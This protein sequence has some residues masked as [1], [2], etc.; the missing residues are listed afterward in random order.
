MP[1]Q[2]VTLPGRII[3]VPGRSTE[4]RMRQLARDHPG[5]P[6]DPG[7]LAADL[8]AR[9]D[10]VPVTFSEPR[11][12]G[13]DWSLLVHGRTYLVRLFLTKRFQDAYTIAAVHPLRMKD[14]HRLAQGCLLVRAHGG[15]AA[16]LTQQQ[17]PRGST[18]H[19]PQLAAEWRRFKSSLADRAVEPRLSQSQA[20][21]L[22]TLDRMIDA[23]ERIATEEETS[24]RPYPYQAIE[25]AGER[26]EGSRSVYEFRLASGRRPDEGAFV[27][28]R[29]EPEQRGQVTRVTDGSVLV[30]FDTPVDW[31]HLRPQGELQVT[32][33]RIVYDTQRE[34]VS[35]LR[36]GQARNSGLLPAVVDHHLRGFRA[37]AAMPRE[38]LDPDQTEAFRRAVATEDLLLV[39]GPPGTGKTRTIRQIA[40]AAAVG[41][42]RVLITSHSNRAVD[43]VLPELPRDLVTVR[44]GHRLRVTAEGQPYLLENQ[45]EALRTD[46]TNVTGLSLVAY[47]QLADAELWTSELRRATAATDLALNTETTALTALANA[48]RRVGGAAQARV[49]GIAAVRDARQRTLDR[50]SKRVDR[51][52]RRRERALSRTGWPMLGSLLRA[53]ARRAERRV[54]TEREQGARLHED[55]RR[56]AAELAVA[57]GE[58]DAATWHDPAVAAAR[59][60]VGEAVRCRDSC[61]ADALTAAS[62]SSAAVA[63]AEV[64]PPVRAGDELGATMSDLAGLTEWLDRR[65]PLHAAR[66]RLLAAWHA[67][68]SE[69]TDQLYP[70]LIGYADVIASTSTGAASRPELSAVD[71]DLAIIDEAGQIGMA[72]A[73]VPLARANRGVLVGDPKQLPPFLNSDVE[74]WGKA[75]GDPVVQNLLAK[76]A[77]ELLLE[78]MPGSHVVPLTQQRRMPEAVADFVS[79][80]FYDKRLTTAARREHR[81]PLFA[82]PLAFVDT[83]RLPATRR[84]EQSGRARE[85]W[86]QPGYSNPAE[87][88]LLVELAT[89]YHRRGA[90]WAV[91]VP[92]RAQVAETAGALTRRVDADTVKLNVGT[93]DA[94]QGGEREVVLVGFTRSNPDGQ[95]GFLRE[96]RRVNVAVSRTSGQL[97][98]VGDTSTLTAARNSGFRALARDLLRHVAE[99]GD[100]RQYAEVSARLAS[101]AR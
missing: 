33:S 59:S 56:L 4:G 61:L 46:I 52:G 54:A 90:S 25:S 28:V 9:V 83:A 95:V 34:A 12:G 68:V 7:Q 8:N 47:E 22:D 66:G 82:S 63:G 98:L 71:F 88:S 40:S 75:V 65:L 43:N 67:E 10:G 97:V 86:G 73:I 49:D 78:G 55:D 20:A 93:V 48:R 30:R 27:Q 32:A 42:E 37:S 45:A 50:H 17:I 21:F 80:A 85:R 92:Y 101:E 79:A 39:L 53:L 69:A 99:R 64:P 100:L 36:T 60:A 77:L 96:L 57:E 3:L 91:I 5:T 41:G 13:D 1:L 2:V 58:L 35:Q 19:W 26:R 16:V 44:V 87:A 74:A 31:S 76:S 70:E 6:A 29:G 84:R 62:A 51:L 89:F 15:W 72:D 24:T 14:H 18:S 38:P 81:D 23:T 94:F 11:P